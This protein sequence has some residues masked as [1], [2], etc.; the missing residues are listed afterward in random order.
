MSKAMTDNAFRCIK[1]QRR[2]AVNRFSWHTFNRNYLIM[3]A[4]AF[5]TSVFRF[6]CQKMDYVS[7]RLSRWGLR[8]AT[9]IHLLPSVRMRGAIPPLHI[10]LCHGA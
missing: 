6:D 1:V 7:S 9:L 10:F 3:T 5:V 4:N 8:H 2:Q